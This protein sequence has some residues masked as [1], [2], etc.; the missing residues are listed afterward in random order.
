MSATLAEVTDAA[1]AL[2]TDEKLALAEQLVADAL[3][4]TPSPHEAAWLAEVQRRR[5]E[6]LSGKVKLVP[7]DEVE[8]ALDRLLG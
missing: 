7:G 5:E 6:V 4:E 1:R 3:S 2:S 8:R